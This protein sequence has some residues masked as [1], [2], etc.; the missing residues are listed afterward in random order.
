MSDPNAGLLAHVVALRG[1]RSVTLRA[2]R[3]DDRDAFEAAFDRLS[4]DARYSRFFVPLREL[5]DKMLDDA[6]NPTP[7]HTVALVAL[8]GEGEGAPIVGGARFGFAPGGEACEFAVTVA[9]DWQGV[10]L[11]RRLMED[12]ITLARARGLRR[13]EGY[14]LPDNMGMRG[15]AA[16][17]GFTDV[18]YPDD[19]T[20]RLVSLKLD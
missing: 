2:V 6:T 1:G 16:R 17:L 4:A 15:L 20:L 3:P 5:P 18:I 19:R 13:M 10:G 12:L 7:D 9:D 8:D 11:A 14:V